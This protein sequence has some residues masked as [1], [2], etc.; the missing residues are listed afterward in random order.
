MAFPLASYGLVNSVFF[1][2]YGN[3]LSCLKGAEERPSSYKEI[4]AAGYVK[5]DFNFDYYY[6]V[7]VVSIINID[8]LFKMFVMNW[9]LYHM[10]K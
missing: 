6:S 5:T 7:W 1:G 8:V 3:T 10:A 4:Y 9:L 2:V